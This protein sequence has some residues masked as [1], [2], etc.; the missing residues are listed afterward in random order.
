MGLND[1]PKAKQ[2]GDSVCTCN[3]CDHKI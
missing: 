1:T 2:F 3:I